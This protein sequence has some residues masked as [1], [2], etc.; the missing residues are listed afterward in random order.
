M[1]FGQTTEYSG[2]VKAKSDKGPLPGAIVVV[3]G[4]KI[5]AQTDFDGNFK[6]SV[7]D[8]LNVLTISYVGFKS[9]EVKLDEQRSL[10]IFLK[11]D[12]NICFFDYQD[13]GFYAMSGA[14][15]NPIG[16]QLYFSTP[17]MFGGTTLKTY[18]AYQTSLRENRFLNASVSLGPFVYGLRI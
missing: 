17:A 18:V 7:P 10:E 1:S 9:Q 16:G 6:I 8:S 3:K 15:N 2:V 13:I 4:T 5:G 11:E 12:C 14:L